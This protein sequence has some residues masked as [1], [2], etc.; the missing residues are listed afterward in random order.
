MIKC[1][2][3]RNRCIKVK[4][5]G[6]I[7]DVMV[8][9]AFLIQTIYE[10]AHQQNPEVAAFYKDNLLGLLLNPKSPVWKEPDHE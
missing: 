8:E 4:T 6:K 9:T 10:N 3:A 1:K 7:R 5:S 2:I